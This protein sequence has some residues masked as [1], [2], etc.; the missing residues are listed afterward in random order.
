MPSTLRPLQPA[1]SRLLSASPARARARRSGSGKNQDAIHFHLCTTRQGSHANR[2]TG[3]VGLLEV[4]PHDIIDLG[5][6]RQV[7][8]EDV[9]LDHILEAT[10]SGLKIGRA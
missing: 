9:Q 6:V 5:K 4:A 2:R 7:S 1:S 8:E 3:R 10:T